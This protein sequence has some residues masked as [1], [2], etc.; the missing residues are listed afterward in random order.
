MYGTKFLERNIH[1]PKTKS[2]GV[3]WG[4]RMYWEKEMAQ[5]DATIQGDSF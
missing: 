5:D 3:G 1:A 2:V 4:G